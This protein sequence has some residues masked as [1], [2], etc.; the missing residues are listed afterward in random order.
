[1]GAEDHIAVPDPVR[2]D[3]RKDVCVLTI[4]NPPSGALSADVRRRLSDELEAAKADDEIKAVILAGNG[5]HFAT[6]GSASEHTV[7]DAP[8]LAE[9]CDR[10]EASPKPVVVAIAGAALGGG[11]DCL[12]YTSDAADE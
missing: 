8:S 7:A 6:G 10:I 5:A 1:M 2:Q 4:D 12:L 9:L 3:R 11:L